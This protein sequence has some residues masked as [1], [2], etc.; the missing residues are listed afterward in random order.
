MMKEKRFDLGAIVKDAGKSAKELIGKTKDGFVEVADLNEDDAFDMQDVAVLADRAGEAAKNAALNIINRAEEKGKK[1]ELELLQPIFPENLFNADF[2]LSK[3]IRI[4]DI[5]KRR[6]ESE[7]CKGSIGYLSEHKGLRIV[8]V[9]RDK[10]DE[11]GISFYPDTDYEVYYI[12]PSDRDKYIA[13]EEYFG[14]L[15]VARINE[16]QKIAQDLGAKHFRVTYKEE[17]TVFTSVSSKG[18]VKLAPKGAK[19][20]TAHKV[21]SNDISSVEVAAEMECPGHSPMEPRLCYLQREPSIQ[22]LIALRMDKNSPISHQKFTLKLSNSSG[23]KETDAIKID[24]ALKAM[25]VGGNTTVVNEVQNESRRYFEYEI[26][27]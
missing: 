18:E 1:L 14:Y 17:K 13:L 24:A 11:F 27:F 9:F 7:V 5:D 12:D 19:L 23:I 10:I 15:K 8:N 4:T 21:A 25:K 20:D 26:D 16:L 2:L 6:A 22:S 3:L